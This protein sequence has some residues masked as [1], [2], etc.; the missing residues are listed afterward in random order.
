MNKN[1]KIC[2]QTLSFLSHNR[3]FVFVNKNGNDFFSE[4][5]K[6]S[7]NNSLFTDKIFFLG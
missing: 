2:L 1:H 6:L 7:Q 3:W 5:P 4:T